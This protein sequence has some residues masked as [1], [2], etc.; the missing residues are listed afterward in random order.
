MADGRQSR[1]YGR[2]SLGMW[3]MPMARSS[4]QRYLD[5][6]TELGAHNYKPLDVVLERGEG[7]WVWDVDGNRYMDCLWEW[8]PFRKARRLISLTSRWCLRSEIAKC[9][10][11]IRTSC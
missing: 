8:H 7:V 9:R 10:L 2:L 4:Q 3:W 11:R 6:E 1:Y 5:I